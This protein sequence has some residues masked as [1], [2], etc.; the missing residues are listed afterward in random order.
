MAQSAL[1]AQ[2]LSRSNSGDPR[3]LE[4]KLLTARFYADQILP[5]AGGLLGP[6]RDGHEAIMALAEDAF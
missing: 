5:R 2:G 6:V 4:A 1:L 3:F